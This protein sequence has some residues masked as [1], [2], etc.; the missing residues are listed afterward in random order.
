MVFI[1]GLLFPFAFVFTAKTAETEV[2]YRLS[3]SFSIFL[4]KFRLAMV[5]CRRAW[6]RHALPSAT[7]AAFF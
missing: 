3:P 7:L 1:F 6:P 5:G 2:S 4:E